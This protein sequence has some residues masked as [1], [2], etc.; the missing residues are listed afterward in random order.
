MIIPSN[1]TRVFIVG[2]SGYVGSHLINYFNKQKGFKSISVGRTGAEI[3]CDIREDFSNFINE[4]RSGDF[5][6]LLS[7]ISSPDICE[8]HFE[9]AYDVNVR[10]TCELIEEVSKVGARVIFSSSDVVYGGQTGISYEDTDIKP[11]GP[12]ALMKA[13]VENFVKNFDQVK[14]VR[15]S[16]VVGA[17]D[18]FSL[19]LKQ[20]SES[21]KSLNIYDGFARAVVSIDDVLIGIGELIKRW[22]E[23]SVCSINFSGPELISRVKI[24][25]L[26][27]NYIYKNLTINISQAPASFWQARPKIIHMQSHFFSKLLSRQPKSVE[28]IVKELGETND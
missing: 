13:E 10:A 2:A 24:A 7:S 26:F 11:V 5:V 27:N 17:Q 9:M 28:E 18:K 12:Y 19:M 8:S 25:T 4:L 22:D 20:C 21:N 1:I 6:V 16:Y 3:L 14:V 15:F 23:F